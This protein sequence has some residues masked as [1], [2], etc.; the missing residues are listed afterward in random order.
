MK[1]EFAAVVVA[2]L[3]LAP[4]LATAQ[5]FSGQVGL[6][7]TSIDGGAERS[8]DLNGAIETALGPV[9]VQLDFSSLQYDD[10]T[11]ISSI[12]LHVF[13]DISPSTAVGLVYYREDWVGDGIY[14]TFWYRSCAYEWPMGSSGVCRAR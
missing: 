4:A 7:F 13:Y 8:I 1:I 2:T 3:T 14:A 6:D 10:G 12:G 5:Q 11:Y 9:G